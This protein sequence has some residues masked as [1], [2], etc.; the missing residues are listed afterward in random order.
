MVHYIADIFDAGLRRIQ[1]DYPDWFIGI[2]QN[3]VVIGLE[4]DHPRARSS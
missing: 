2:R 4:F 3:G 1:A